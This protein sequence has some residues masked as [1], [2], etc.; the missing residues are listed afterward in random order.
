MRKLALAAASMALIMNT[1]SAAADQTIEVDQITDPRARSAH[2]MFRFSPDLVRLDPGE[3]LIFLNSRSHHTVHSIPQFWPES[4]P[5]V[6]ISNKPRAEVALQQEGFYGFTCRRHG[7]YGMTLL[8][9]VGNPEIG[10]DF[11]ERINA[12]RASSREKD[13]F[14][15]LIERY[16]GSL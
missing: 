13:S 2:E 9:V 14:R 5:K 3:K 1:F 16:R 15:A 12:M 10:A 6:A 4:T 11:E 8:V 7:T